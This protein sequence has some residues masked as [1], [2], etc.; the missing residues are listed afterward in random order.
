MIHK[1][2]GNVIHLWKSQQCSTFVF[3]L[4]SLKTTWALKN[5]LQ[6]LVLFSRF[7]TTYYL[8]YILFHNIL[9]SSY[10]IVFTFLKVKT[11]ELMTIKTSLLLSFNDN[12]NVSLVI[13]EK[14]RCISTLNRW[15]NNDLNSHELFLAQGKLNLYPCFS[16]Q[17]LCNKMYLNCL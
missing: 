17:R 15:P 11:N 7:W 14:K 13:L 2:N 12:Q 10:L 1:L 9:L 16:W 6:K 4:D 8:T 3:D 5:E